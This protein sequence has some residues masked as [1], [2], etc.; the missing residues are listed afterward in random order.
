MT[1]SE[2]ISDNVEWENQLQ[3]LVSFIKIKTEYID[4]IMKLKDTDGAK[5]LKKPLIYDLAIKIWI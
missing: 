3:K 2:N 1:M 5:S 4:E